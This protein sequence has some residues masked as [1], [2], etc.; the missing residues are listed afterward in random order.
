M[1]SIDGLVK[2]VCSDWSHLT[3]EW[4][5]PLM[6]RKKKKKKK[7]KKNV[8]YFFFIEKDPIMS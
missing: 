2:Y 3:P 1:G 6:S 4:P 5:H 7:K 8:K